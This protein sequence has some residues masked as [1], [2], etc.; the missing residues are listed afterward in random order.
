MSHLMSAIGFSWARRLDSVQEAPLRSVVAAPEDAGGVAEN[1][2][3]AAKKRRSLAMDMHSPKTEAGENRTFG[4]AVRSMFPPGHIPTHTR[5]R[6]SGQ[7][8][9]GVR[10]PKEC[11][12][13]GDRLLEREP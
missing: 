11:S 13:Q 9:A 4:T 7:R 3:Q 2:Q 12:T 6:Y 10:G 8:A 5:P 1:G